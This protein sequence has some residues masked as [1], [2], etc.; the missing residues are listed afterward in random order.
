MVLIRLRLTLHFSPPTLWQQPKKT[1]MSDL[2]AWVPQQVVCEEVN[3][4]PEVENSPQ[5]KW[6][7]D[8]F[9]QSDAPVALLHLTS[10]PEFRITNILKLATDPEN[11]STLEINMYPIF[12]G[13]KTRHNP[14]A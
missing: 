11:N 6:D 12:M 8:L 9:N 1:I 3:V 7:G 10:N 4:I 14:E 5:L 13:E 2:A